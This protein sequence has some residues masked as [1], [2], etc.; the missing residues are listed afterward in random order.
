MREKEIIAKHYRGLIKERNDFP[1][2]TVAWS[3]CWE[4]GLRLLFISYVLSWHLPPRPSAKETQAG[5]TQQDHNSSN[6]SPV[7]LFSPTLE[8]ETQWAW[9][10]GANKI[11]PW[12]KILKGSVVIS[13][14]SH[15]LPG[16]R[17]LLDHIIIERFW[18]LQESASEP[19]HPQLPKPLLVSTAPSKESKK[20]KVIAGVSGPCAVH[21]RLFWGVVSHRVYIAAIFSETKFLPQVLLLPTCSKCRRPAVV[22]SSYWDQGSVKAKGPNQGGGAK[23]W[24][25]LVLWLFSTVSGISR[26]G[27]S[28]WKVLLPRGVGIPLQS[29][30]NL[31][32]RC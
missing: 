18:D 16:G 8:V 2:I 3:G 7:S 12:T 6:I 11:P 22:R 13:A 14:N 15:A 21:I 28:F 32:G 10:W 24:R 25:L 27:G 26:E 17:K 4:H 5:V 20:S 19:K 1:N 31:I 23:N 9:Q 29:G 30:R